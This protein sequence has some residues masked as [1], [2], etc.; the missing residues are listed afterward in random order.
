VRRCCGL[1]IAV[2]LVGCGSQSQ[3][4]ASQRSVDAAPVASPSPPARDPGPD[5]SAV[6][7]SAASAVSDFYDSL[8]VKD[9]ESAWSRMSASRRSAV[10]GFDAWKA[11]Y[12][13][14]TAVEV[15]DPSGDATDA[16]HATVAVTMRSTDRDVCDRVVHQ[17]FSGTVT[18]SRPAGRW[19]ITGADITKT[20][21]GTVRT[22]ASSCPGAAGPSDQQASADA[23][24]SS[25]DPGG[26]ASGDQVGKVCYPGVDVPAVN[27]PAS[28]IPASTIPAFT[29]NGQHYP[30]RHL[31][32]VHLK[33]VHLPGRHLAGGCLQAPAAFAPQRTT[34]LEDGYS[35]IDS[36]Y[37]PTLTSRYWSSTGD[38]SSYPDTTAPGFG[39]YNAAG[40]PKNQYVR[41]YVRRDGTMVSGYWR[42]SPSD[43][44][45]TCQVIGC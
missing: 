41:S 34:V 29:I 10:G 14:T 24:G 18:V 32:A 9:Y 35:R 45:P 44:L 4:G 31:P 28:T 30:A 2:L 8:S 5:L 19:L 25:T 27:I 11:G 43:G 15:D 12:A 20:G 6:D 42:N 17:R 21:G 36:D 23:G 39:Q 1:L 37:S 7:R 3:H 33:G 38:A 13:T 22:D 26:S 40:F 16:S